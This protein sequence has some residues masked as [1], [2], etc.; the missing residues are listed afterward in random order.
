MLFNLLCVA[1]QYYRSDELFSKTHNISVIFH[2][3]D[4]T[5]SVMIVC[6]LGHRMK[7]ILT[8]LGFRRHEHSDRR[9]SIFQRFCFVCWARRIDPVFISYMK[10][11]SSY[12]LDGATDAIRCWSLKRACLVMFMTVCQC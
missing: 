9:T 10:S 8:F 3:R 1:N 2:F 11:D 6:I 5:H 7:I 4:E 12:F